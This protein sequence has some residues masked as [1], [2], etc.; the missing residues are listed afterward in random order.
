MKKV[1]TGTVFGRLSVVDTKGASIT[2]VCTCGNI[3]IYK[4][5]VLRAGK[6]NSCG[7]LIQEYQNRGGRWSK[8]SIRKT[9]YNNMV[10]RCYNKNSQNYVNYGNRG[11]TVCEEWLDSFEQFSKDM[12]PRPLNKSSLD[13]IDNNKGYFK[14]NCRWATYEEQ[15]N[16]RR[17]NKN[18]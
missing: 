11:I 17:N 3:K 9:T 13:R 2:C 12:G 8:K 14:N 4:G 10:A 5:S 1:K 7:C 18:N 6:V 15:N 16:N